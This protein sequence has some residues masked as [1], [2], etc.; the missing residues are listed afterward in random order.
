MRTATVE[1][2]PR[3]QTGQSLAAGTSQVTGCWFCCLTKSICSPV[4]PGSMKGAQYSNRDESKISPLV[5]DLCFI[6]RIFITLEVRIGWQ[7]NPQIVS[8][9]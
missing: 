8:V 9:G 7:P 5:I 6:L 4:K 1:K 2:L 3:S